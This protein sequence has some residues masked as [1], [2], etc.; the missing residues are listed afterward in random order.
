MITVICFAY[1]VVR[2]SANK[3]MTEV[4]P[5]ACINPNQTG[6]NPTIWSSAG[7]GCLRPCQRISPVSSQH[8]NAARPT[9]VGN[10]TYK[11]CV[12]NVDR[13]SEIERLWVFGWSN[14]DGW[15]CAHG[16]SGESVDRFEV[17]RLRVASTL[18]I[19]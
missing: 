16:E 5:F 17:I 7:A 3:W 13:V 2:P 12:E 11:G 4:C 19:L 10:W 15:G 1:P 6:I 9:N 8:W 14:R 18:G